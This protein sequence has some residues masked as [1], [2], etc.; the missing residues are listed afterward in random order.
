MII[1]FNDYINENNEI[2]NKIFSICKHAYNTSLLDID[3][4]KNNINNIDIK[5]INDIHYELL[6]NSVSHFNFDLVKILVEN[7]A[8]INKKFHLNFTAL[9]ELVYARHMNNHE[10]NIMKI[11]YYL[12]E[13]GANINDTCGNSESNILMLAIDNFERSNNMRDQ[14][15]LYN[16][17]TILIEL[18]A[19]LL[20]KNNIGE[21]AYDK[22]TNNM[23]EHIKKNDKAYRN[24]NKQITSS[25]FNI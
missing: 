11:F 1:K 4:I 23:I 10:H 2:L 16:I 6:L 19:D 22:I 8:D 15:I 14:K 9:A 25:K 3:Y 5:I 21:C 17:I 7:G 24:Y 18:D 20:R 13:N 12:I